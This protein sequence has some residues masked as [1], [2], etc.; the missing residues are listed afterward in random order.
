MLM[1]SGRGSGLA[2]DWTTVTM[3]A[4]PLSVQIADTAQKALVTSHKALGS[5]WGAQGLNLWIC[6]E[7]SAG[8]LTRVG[9]GVFN[10]SLPYGGMQLFALSATLENLPAGTYRVGLCGS[11]NDSANWDQD[12][13]SY[14]TAVVTN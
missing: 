8:V 4:A 1:T 14:T 3:L 2:G 11:S 13:F 5:S 12:E 6:R 9:P 7:D 10:L